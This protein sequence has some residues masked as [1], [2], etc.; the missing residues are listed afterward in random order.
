MYFISLTTH[1]PNAGLVHLKGLTQLELLGLNYTRV[2]DAG[3][4][5]LKGLTKLNYLILN[6]TM[7]TDEGVGELKE[8]LP[9]CDIRR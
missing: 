9:N 5:H 7:V 8:A 3:L 1:S 4:V 6:D 2:T